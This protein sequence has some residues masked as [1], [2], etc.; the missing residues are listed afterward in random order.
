M[1]VRPAELGFAVEE[2]G[3]EGFFG[4]G[5]GGVGVGFEGGEALDGF[6]VLGIDFEDAAVKRD[7]APGEAHDFVKLAELEIGGGVPLV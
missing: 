5:L 2:A 6:G 3:H 4:F 1:R 7:G